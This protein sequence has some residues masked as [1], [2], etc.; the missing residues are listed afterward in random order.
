MCAVEEEEVRREIREELVR[1]FDLQAGPVLRARLL[2]VSEQEYVLVISMHHIVTDGWSLGVLQRE[3]SV[4]YEAYRKGEP[5]P[6]PELAVQYADYASWQREQLQGEFLHQG[7][8]YWKGQLAGAPALLDLPADHPRAAV[9]SYR[10]AQEVMKLRPELLER[11][12]ALGRREGVTLF[13]VLLGAWQVLLSKYSGSED[14]VVGSPIA[15][16]NRR[17]IEDLIGFFVNMLVLRTDLSGDPSFRQVLGRVREVALSGYEHQEVP[18]EKL[19]A[20]LQP[21][22]SLSHSP[23]FQVA[24]QLQEAGDSTP[25]LSR[26]QMHSVSGVEPA[27]AKFDLQLDFGASSD[28]FAA[29]LV[30][31]TDLFEQETI[32]RMLCHLE[33]VLEQV[34]A[35][36]DVRISELELMGSEERLRLLYEWNDTAVEYPRGQCIHELFEEQ[37]SKTPDAVAAVYEGESLSYGELNRQANQLGHYLRE[38]GVKP[39]A[40]V[41]ICLER[42]LAMMVALLGV[43]KAGGAY[44]PLD[45]NYPPER[46]SFMLEDSAPLALLTQRSLRGL[47]QGTKADLSLL[48]VDA[49]L[50][51]TQPETN[52]GRESVGLK[53]KHLAYVIYTSGSTGTPKAA[54]IEHRGLCNYLA[55]TAKAC[56]AEVA[57]VSSS[58][59]FDATVTSLYTPLL[60]G[61]IVRLVGQGEEVEDLCAQLEQTGWRGLL[62]LTP[63]HFTALG[64]RVRSAGARSSIDVCVVGGDVLS[65]GMIQLWRQIQSNLRVMNEYG[66]TETVVGC[67]VY[68][69]PLSGVTQ[70]VPVGRPI[71]NTRIYIVDGHCSPVPVGV[72]G[73]IHI[74]GVGVA[75]GYL[76]RPG[77]TAERFAPDPFAEEPGER[78]YRTGDLARHRADGNIEFLGRNDFQVKIRGFRIEL[79]EIEARLAELEGVREAVVIARE[80]APGEKRLVAYVVGEADARQLRAHLKQS[81][82]DHMVPA[83]FVRLG[84]LPLTINGKLDRKALPA[85][86]VTEDDASYLAPR[87]PVEEVLAKI[88]AEVLRVERV[89]VNDNFFELGGHSLATVQVSLYVR[90]IFGIKLSQR[91]FFDLSTIAELASLLSSDARYADTVKRISSLVLQ[92]RSNPGAARLSPVMCASVP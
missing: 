11:L 13:M 19:V 12:Q 34:S 72:V 58:I 87:T 64:D 65:A 92:A 6:L 74:G 3:M 80:D 88:W 67:L 16:R 90:E 1:P 51:E 41:G 40:R 44:V 50:W 18:F 26:L 62:K 59:S 35:N 10:G 91:V 21:E 45:P 22:R 5:S 32:Q 70:D 52:P 63:R 28:G 82:P 86:Q 7:L 17:E 39:D 66:P 49:P 83:A 30:Y 27:T 38:L 42:S 48:E 57:F 14:V 73:E 85:P 31:S 33:R 79:G 9:Q 8:A 81:L 2:R 68:D 71:P 25:G 54:A 29:V 56:K 24:F 23:L 55:Y 75:R 76:N 61:G 60:Y 46:L 77:L 43:L 53:P 89:G 78:V 47:L 69:V 84:Q 36:A 37:V 20:E 4:L 15:G